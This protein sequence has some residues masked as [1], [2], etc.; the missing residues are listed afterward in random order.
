MNFETLAYVPQSKYGFG[1][2]ILEAENTIPL[3]PG[4]KNKMAIIS[5]LQQAA[6]KAEKCQPNTLCYF[7]V[8]TL[9]A[10]E[11]NHQ[12]SYPQILHNFIKL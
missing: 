12:M 1:I 2:L 9:M 8:N 4:C 6:Y 5:K 7:H 10:F 11:F 3:C